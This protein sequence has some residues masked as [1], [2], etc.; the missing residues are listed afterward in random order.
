MMPAVLTVGA[1]ALAGCGGGSDTPAQSTEMSGGLAPGAARTVDGKVYTCA[2]DRTENCEFD[3]ADPP[4]E[5]GNGITITDA[6]PPTSTSASITTE[7]DDAKSDADAAFKKAE[8]AS[9]GDDPKTGYADVR[10]VSAD[11][12]ANAKAI[13]DA[14]TEINAALAAAKAALAKAEALPDTA[15]GKARLVASI[16][17]DVE[18]I[19]GNQKTV[20]DLADEIRGKK[21]TPNT[22]AHWGTE[23]AKGLD[24][25][26]KAFVA[27]PAGTQPLLVNV[28]ADDVLFHG[29]TRPDGAKNF[30][31]VAVKGEVLATTAL[32]AAE[33][34]ASSIGAAIE[35]GATD[36]P[37]SFTC[38]S[39][40]G[41]EA[42]DIG[43]KIG[44]GWHFIITAN[45]EYWYVKNGDG[46]YTQA[47]FAEWGMWFSDGAA[48]TDPKLVN[49]F[50]GMGVGSGSLVSG[51]TDVDDSLDGEATYTGEAE[52][53]STFRAST[54]GQ[55]AA[56]VRSGHFTADVELKASFGATAMLE[57]MIDGFEG[58][59]VNAGWKIEIEKGN[60]GSPLN[61]KDGGHFTHETYGEAGQRPTGIV[62]RFGKDFSDGAVTGVYHAD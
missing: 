13:L 57:G 4:E 31:N 48:P 17:A 51:D 22:A 32:T 39:A 27:N 19:E 2:R 37:G 9:D 53:L 26:L 44:D 54:D 16:E 58:P 46:E 61:V 24:L 11:A 20:K 5:D 62:G 28:D 55:A 15:V 38:L 1:L 21:S 35:N 56:A 33:F 23:A 14:E 7:A 25:A 36:L 6:P 18:E 3:A 41:C 12:A 50:A 42:V 49:A 29:T 59:A 30:N 34:G 8:D 60:L 40:S 10:G 47:V 43:D 45:P 52:G